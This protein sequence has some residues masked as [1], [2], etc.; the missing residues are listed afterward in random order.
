MQKIKLFILI[1][2]MS[3]SA[4][5]KERKLYES[6]YV[7]L[8]CKG[9]IEFVLPDKTRVD[10]LTDTHAIEYNKWDTHK[11]FKNSLWVS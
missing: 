3:T 6:D 1:Y 4:L 5:S 11:L 8:H 9:Q 2:L 7:K 10:C